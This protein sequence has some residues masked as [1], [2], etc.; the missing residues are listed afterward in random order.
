MNNS[1]KIEVRHI[2]LL[3][4]LLAS[5]SCQARENKIVKIPILKANYPVID[6]DLSDSAWK[7]AERFTDFKEW[8]PD[9]GSEP[10]EKTEVYL[11]YNKNHIYIGI[12]CYDSEPAKIMMHN[13]VKDNELIAR[14]DWVAI[15]LDIF[16]DELMAYF[17]MVN[18]FGNQ[19]DGTLNMDGHPGLNF[20]ETWMSAG[21]KTDDG[22]SV[23]L[24]I[25]FSSLPY[26]FDRKNAIMGFKVARFISRK[27]EEVDYPEFQRNDVPHLSQ[28]QKIQFSDIQEK[29][30]KIQLPVIDEKAGYHSKERLSKNYDTKTL[31][32]RI[33]AWGDA[34]VIDYLLF[35]K[36]DINHSNNTFRFPNRIQEN[37]VESKFAGINY[38][39]NKQ[40]KNLDA[41]LLH[42]QTTS[43]IIIQN[44]TIRYEKYFN[45]HNRESIATSFSVAK[46]FVST[47]VGKAIEEGYIKSVNDPITK[48]IP[49]LLTRDPAFREIKIKDLLKMS[50]GLRY[51]ESSG[52]DDVITYYHP[53]LK[54]AALE[55][56]EIMEKPGNHFLYNNYNPLLVGI[57]LERTTGKTVSKYL[58]DKIWKPIG[59]EYSASWSLDS[60]DKGFEKM[61]SG[62]NARAIDFAKFGQLFLKKGIWQGRQ[63][64]SSQWINEATQPGN[65]ESSYY[66]DG[67]FFNS[68]GGYYRYFWWGLKRVN[69]LNDF[70]ALGN[71]GQ[72]I[73]VSPQKNLVIIRNGVEY[74]IPSMRWGIIF[75]EFA[76]KI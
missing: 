68:V 1:I 5:T 32:G 37:W 67:D 3:F 28:F 35:P 29:K 24:A 9:A 52:D 65:E 54:R 60:K 36:R 45:G 70:F 7:Y 11:T 41:F 74:G 55:E 30:N 21:K 33:H 43:F 4:V 13:Y 49:E 19:I 17:F 40:I 2:I 14:D 8:N 71:K 75:Y 59:M 53:D 63:I 12:H 34:S 76:S 38:F 22:Y 26:H 48:Y 16:N 42:T 69:G 58:E 31:D 51:E 62:L 20:S 6:G 72:Y 50:S 10:S 25:P 47:L 56:A 46:S 73:Y 18:P 15:A 66:P 57:I 61:E 64:I 44:D 23:E 27:S 39:G